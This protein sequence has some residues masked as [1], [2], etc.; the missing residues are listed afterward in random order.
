MVSRTTMRENSPLEKRSN[1]ENNKGPM[2]KISANGICLGKEEAGNE[3]S[4]KNSE[5]SENFACVQAE[6]LI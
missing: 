2:C 3:N 4:G 5:R 1:K 6:T